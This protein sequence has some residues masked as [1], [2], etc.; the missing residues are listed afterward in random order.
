MK[1]RIVTGIIN[2]DTKTAD[3]YEFDG[4][5]LH[6]RWNSEETEKAY[7]GSCRCES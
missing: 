4:F 2:P 7:V 5:H 6:I 3:L 1:R